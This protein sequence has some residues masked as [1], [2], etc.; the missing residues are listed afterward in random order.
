MTMDPLVSTRVSIRWPPNAA[1]EDCD[2]LVIQGRT[3]FF[4]DLRIFVD[5][6]QRQGEIDWATAGWKKLLPASA[7]GQPRASFAPL[8]DSRQCAPEYTPSPAADEDKSPPADEGTFTTLPNGDVLETG[9]MPN[10]DVPGSPIQ[11]YE[12]VWR[13]LLLPKVVKCLILAREDDKV[14]WGRVAGWEVGMGVDYQ[15]KFWATRRD[16]N[17]S[18]EW[19][20]VVGDG[21]VDGKR[22]PLGETRAGDEDPP[23]EGDVITTEDGKRWRVI[24]NST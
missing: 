19:K 7:D 8:I 11:E 14:F 6:H 2:V 21:K 18:G 13:R 24:E 1:T 20:D 12:E 16:L 23:K 17:G 5:G 4:L 3:G 9:S 10:P 22:R 15:S